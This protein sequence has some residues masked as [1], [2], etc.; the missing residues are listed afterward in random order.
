[1]SLCL[2]TPEVSTS[3]ALCSSAASIQS[4]SEL[5]TSVYRARNE[6]AFKWNEQFPLE[7]GST[8]YALMSRL[9]LHHTFYTWRER[10]NDMTG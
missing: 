6:P 1:M 3:L 9:T 10:E 4:H 2:H 7:T 8:S 5:Q